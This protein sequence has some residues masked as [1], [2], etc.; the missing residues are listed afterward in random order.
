MSGMSYGNLTQQA[1]LVT[2]GL[3][4]WASGATRPLRTCPRSW[5]SWFSGVLGERGSG[6]VDPVD[7][8]RVRGA[9]G[10]DRRYG[11]LLHMH[12]LVARHGQPG[13]VAALTPLSVDGMIVAASTTLLGGFAVRP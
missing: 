7:H 2:G 10:L 1:C 4:V 5:A 8:D 13:W 11:F 3:R 9:A 6:S 12:M